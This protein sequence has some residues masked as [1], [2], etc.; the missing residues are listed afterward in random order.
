MTEIPTLAKRRLQAQVIKPIYEEMEKALGA[1]KAQRILA[2]AIR[3]ASL[4]EARDFAEKAPGKKTDM[5]SFIV[6]YD[7][8]THDSA[9]EVEVIEESK[10]RYDFDVTRCQ[11]AEMYREMGLGQIG[12]LLSCHRDGTFCEGTTRRSL[13]SARRPSCRGP[14]AALSA[15]ATRRPKR[16]HEPSVVRITPIRLPAQLKSGRSWWSASCISA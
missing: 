12:H 15:I 8:W 5:A 3:K 7:L 4:A 11:F 9:L 10:D 2:D 6:L 1:E 16:L 14:I 13:W